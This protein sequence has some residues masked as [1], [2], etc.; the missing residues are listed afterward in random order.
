MY[1]SENSINFEKF[2]SIA[3]LVKEGYLDPKKTEKEA[4]E[5]NEILEKRKQN[6]YETELVNSLDDFYNFSDN[7]LLEKIKYVVLKV[8]GGRIRLDGFLQLYRNLVWFESLGIEGI[9]VDDDITNSF[10]EGVKMAYQNG[11]LEYIQ[12]L[13]FQFQW[14][15]DDK[16]KF[17]KKYDKFKEFVIQINDNLNTNKYSQTFENIS[18]SISDNNISNLIE[19]L[20]PDNKLMLTENDARII[21]DNLVEANTKTIGQFTDGLY[22]RY[23]DEGRTVSYLLEKEKNFLFRL[24]SLLA[25]NNR[26]QPENKKKLREVALMFLKNSI[27]QMIEKDFPQN[28]K[29]ANEK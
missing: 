25:E 19:L 17:A 27:W 1:F 2:Y 9:E 3:T 8:K 20:S 24:Y 29:I 7:E 4:T 28:D 16:N 11:I 15:K 26:L 21:Y 22:R 5:L 18:T 10:K 14:S 12:N 23:A 13:N 6:I